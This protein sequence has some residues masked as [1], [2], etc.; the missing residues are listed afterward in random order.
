MSLARYARPSSSFTLYVPSKGMTL[1]QQVGSFPD[2]LPPLIPNTGTK[3]LTAPQ[4]LDEDDDMIEN[5]VSKVFYY[6]GNKYIVEKEIDIRSYPLLPGI[7][8][9][10]FGDLYTHKI[11]VCMH[12]CDFSDQSIQAEA[13]QIKLET[14]KE[15]YALFEVR[16]DMKQLPEHLQEITYK[17]LEKNIFMQ[18]TNIRGQMPG[19]IGLELSWPHMQIAFQILNRFVATFYHNQFINFQLFQ[20]ALNLLNLPD[21]NVRFKLV[22]FMKTYISSHAGHLEKIFFLIQNKIVGH[23]EGRNA[24]NCYAPILAFLSHVYSIAPTPLPRYMEKFLRNA[25]YP[26][27]S[28]SKM[29]LYFPQLKQLLKIAM[30]GQSQLHSC[31]YH[32][33]KRC[34]PRANG[35]KQQQYLELLFTVIKSMKSSV[36]THISK[37]LFQF[38]ACCVRS[39]NAKLSKTVLEL[40]TGTRLP[41]YLSD[42]SKVAITEMFD[43]IYWASSCHWSRVV[44]E[45]AKSALNTI[46]KSKP[47]YYQQ[48]TQSANFESC[49]LLGED[50]L[51]KETEILRNWSMISKIAFQNT[52]E[53]QRVVYKELMFRPENQTKV[54]S[55]RVASPPLRQNPLMKVAKNAASLGRLSQ[56]NILRNQI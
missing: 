17:M 29:N 21:V 18:D 38:F 19:M 51:E 3:D 43:S 11:E 33:F 37:E 44:Q 16:A 41:P 49:I 14:L 7:T 47:A 20:R 50:E 6:T 34:W 36:V 26:L 5:E 35:S 27:L 10:S 23:A 32:Q 54:S 56:F 55:G 25:F 4:Q 2:T 45:T 8:A 9:S 39:P 1:M 53:R 48:K 28:S 12:I 30:P 42:N 46:R 40:W 22:E 31:F 15:V 52:G 13:K 24:F